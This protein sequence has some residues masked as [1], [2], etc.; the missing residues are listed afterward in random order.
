LRGAGAGSDDDSSCG[1]ASS[2]GSSDSYVSMAVEPSN[3][4][5]ESDAGTDTVEMA[6]QT[7]G[8]RAMPGE[9]PIGKMV[10]RQC[11]QSECG[12][13]VVD[14]RRHYK[15]LHPR[16][17]YDLEQGTQSAGFKVGVQNRQYK[18]KRCVLCDSLTS[19]IDQHLVRQHSLV[20]GSPEYNDAVERCCVVDPASLNDTRAD[21]NFLTIYRGFLADR[22]GGGAS[23]SAIDIAV[24][25]IHLF[26]PVMSGPEILALGQIG[27]AGGL[28]DNL[29]AKGTHRPKT[30]QTY[31]S[32][33][34]KFVQWVASNRTMLK[35]LNITAIRVGELAPV[36]KRISTSLCKDIATDDVQRTV[37]GENDMDADLPQYV[38]RYLRGEHET[39]R[40]VRVY[41]KRIDQGQTISRRAQVVVRDNLMVLLL[42]TN[43]KRSG[44]IR[45]LTQA[46][47]DEA[48][49]PSGT[50]KTELHV[51]R[52]K[53]ARHGKLCSI[54]VAAGTL[55][56]LKLYSKMVGL[57]PSCPYLFRSEA[58]TAFRS[59]VSANVLARVGLTT[60]IGSLREVCRSIFRRHRVR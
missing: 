20:R 18:R 28:V 56:D 13:H 14:L 53:E 54:F 55:G 51:A 31:V 15:L 26:L 47:V 3:V 39:V 60:S 57:N 25:A 11:K 17:D 49:I 12:V 42:L 43:A 23:K 46:A 52:H 30:L 19:R 48:A 6:T 29:L 59:S 21:E 9:K 4:R 32:A 22:G 41:L 16:L 5:R 1:G 10:T 24:A 40:N 2:R 58:S 8:R 35:A 33:L 45:H 44:D 34:G 7:D 36:L 27:T 50:D 38:G 37:S